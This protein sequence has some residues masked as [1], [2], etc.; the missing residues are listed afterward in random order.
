MNFQSRTIQEQQSAEQLLFRAGLAT[1]IHGQ[2]LHQQ[3]IAHAFIG[4]HLMGII[5]LHCV[6]QR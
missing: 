3:A 2:G 6:A 5:G 4:E 1:A